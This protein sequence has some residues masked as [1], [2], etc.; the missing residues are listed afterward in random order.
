MIPGSII[1]AGIIIAGAVIYST[2]AKSIAP[3]AN[4]PSINSGNNAVGGNN[5]A[6]QVNQSDV[7]LGNVDAKVTMIEF[8]DFQCP[9]CAKFYKEIEI[10][11][12]R[13]YVA[14]GKVRVVYKPLAFLDS[15]APVKESQNAVNAV[16][17]A[18]EQGKFW[19]M[20]DKIFETEYSEVEKVVAGQ[21]ESN[22]FNGNLVK[23]FFQKAAGDLEMNLNDFSTCY[24]SGKYKDVYVDI[25]K[26]ASLALNGQ[27]GTP[28]VFLN[29]VQ[30]EL[31][32]N[33][34]REFDYTAFKAQIDALLK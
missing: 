2:G 18:G 21:M 26:E 33:A 25:M 32:M 3:L 1:V 23:E 30:A 34:Q 13:D 16:K 17:C 15:Q 24:D 14:T 8:G 11:L 12:K 27:V 28:S 4:N 29:G 6:P 31:T 10:P 22:E 7:I 9:F 5:L 19:A 20:H